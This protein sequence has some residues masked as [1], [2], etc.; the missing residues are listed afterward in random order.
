[1][2]FIIAGTIPGDFTTDKVNLDLFTSGQIG[3][4]QSVNITATLIGYKNQILSVGVRFELAV[5]NQEKRF[6]MASL[7]SVSMFLF[8]DKSTLTRG[9]TKRAIQLIED[10]YDLAQAH[11]FGSFCKL[12]ENLQLPL[13][14]T[15]LV[16]KEIYEQQIHTFLT[17][18]NLMKKG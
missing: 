16:P 5:K 11:C 9:K 12:S 8:T 4:D 15:G 6:V 17:K 7:N 14:A 3:K 10:C 2:D 13:I 18:N 1:M